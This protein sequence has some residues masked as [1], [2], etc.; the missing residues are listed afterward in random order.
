MRDTQH[1]E[2]P[3]RLTHSQII[4]ELI[5]ALARGSSDHSTVALS[6]NAKGDTQISVSVR[7]G[8]G[9][10]TTA[11]EAAAK[12]TELYDDLAALSTISGD[13]STVKLTRNAKGE[14]Q[15]EVA[16]ESTDNAETKAR[17]LYDELAREYPVGGNGA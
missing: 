2:R 10:D 1:D 17:E 9:D 12:A 6:R 7:T 15:I 16:V 11:D 14:T 8:E 13:R 5:G 3:R 4:D